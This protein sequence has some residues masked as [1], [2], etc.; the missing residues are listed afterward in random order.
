MAYIQN[1]H[2]PE[3]KRVFIALQK[4]YGIGYSLS[5]RICDKLGISPEITVKEMSASQVEQLNGYLTRKVL[6]GHQLR[7]VN[8]LSLLRLVGIG[9]YRGFR[10]TQG[11]PSRG[12][13][14]H[15]NSR[16]ARRLKGR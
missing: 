1:T 13:R 4:I 14:T 9:C 10:Y 12:Q 5:N 8:R 16:T 7:R 3:K 11:L 15:G 2:L 6:T